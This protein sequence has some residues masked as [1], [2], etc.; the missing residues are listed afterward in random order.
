MEDLEMTMKRV[1]LI[2]I[3]QDLFVNS[4]EKY[5]NYF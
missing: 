3:K 1:C 2:K 4:C 5:F